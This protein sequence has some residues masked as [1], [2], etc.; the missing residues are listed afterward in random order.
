M[1]NPS[2]GAASVD[3]GS[4]SGFAGSSPTKNVMTDGETIFH[5]DCSH[6]K[7]A[8]CNSCKVQRSDQS[9]STIMRLSARTARNKQQS[10]LFFPL[11]LSHHGF[12]LLLPGFILAFLLLFSFVVLDD[13]ADVWS[14]L[15]QSRP[16]EYRP[17]HNNFL[18][19][20]VED[21]VLRTLN[22]R[23]TT[24]YSFA[25]Q[26][27]DNVHVVQYISTAVNMLRRIK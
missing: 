11:S 17:W 9:S 23:S 8:R 21:W 10:V 14:I 27:K 15:P 22:D 12:L 16:P 2:A 18:D 7:S 26:S 3:L 6:A 1:K 4:G 5:P 24:R 20:R 13:D 19:R 25:P